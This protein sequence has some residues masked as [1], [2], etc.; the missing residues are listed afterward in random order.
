M[1]KELFNQMNQLDRI[2]YRQRD[3]GTQYLIIG[4]FAS[5]LYMLLGIVDFLKNNDKEWMVFCVWSG[6]I[7]LIVSYI[8]QIISDKSRENKLDKDFS[9]RFEVKKK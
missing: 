5:I 1:N 3:S 9:N 6:L 2:E 4:F 7:I 8:L